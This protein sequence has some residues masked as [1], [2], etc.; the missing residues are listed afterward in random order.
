MALITPTLPVVGSP[1]T[2]ED[3]KILSALTTITSAINGGLDLANLSAALQ[4][5]V[6][7]PT[8]S[9]LPVTPT[10]G[11]VINYLADPGL[12]VVW[13]L[14]YRAASSSA[15][16]WEFLG[17]APNIGYSEAGVAV[18][19]GTI[20]GVTAAC[21]LAGDYEVEWG[22]TLLGSSAA[23]PAR[24]Q[25]SFLPSGGSPAAATG[26]NTG[27]TF[28]FTASGQ[29]QTGYLKRVITGLGIGGFRM[30]FNNTGLTATAYDNVVA[31][32][33]VRVG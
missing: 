23:G 1:N 21:P 6:V 7:A 12:G 27:I 2:S 28:T 11:Q 18:A 30:V 19:S 16:K 33:P 3:P 25:L 5:V 13:Q 20:F 32:R 10:D 14:R 8:V 24:V 15:Y 31:V 26:T 4:A 29:Q 9:S 22:T 17:G